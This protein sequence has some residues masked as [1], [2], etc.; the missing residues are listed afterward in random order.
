MNEGA[1]SMYEVQGTFEDKFFIST[2]EKNG[3]IKS[4]D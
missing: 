1:N 4:L 3:G 2:L